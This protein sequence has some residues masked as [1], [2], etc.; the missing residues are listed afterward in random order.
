[1]E[2]ERR[3]SSAAPRKKSAA[4]A[5]KRKEIVRNRMILLGVLIVLAV[6]LIVFAVCRLTG[7]FDGIP[8]N[9]ILS[10]DEKGEVV[11][12]EVTDFNESFYSKGALKSYI[13][14]EIGT[15]NDE[16]GSGSVKLDKLKVKGKKAYAKMSYTSPKVYSAFT[17]YDLYQGTVK[18][19]LEAGYDFADAFVAVKDGEKKD[20][21]KT[22]DIVSQPK[23]KV[24][25]IRENI[26]VQVD[27]KIL[28]VS[29][30]NTTMV[31]ESTVAI[32]QIDGNNDATQLTYIV[33]KPAQK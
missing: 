11:C 33:Y 32:A 10:V 9:S 31:D 17:G 15:Y 20:S 27:G 29:D 18:K 6:A 2:K 1:M 8:E 19:A 4:G 16:N 12:E 3:R 21:A 14:K 25:V 7:A 24:I 13:K 28:Y 5:K 30:S 23:L 26:E 22:L